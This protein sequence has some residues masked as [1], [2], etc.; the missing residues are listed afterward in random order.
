[1]ASVHCDFDVRGIGQR[2]VALKNCRQVQEIVILARNL[3]V[4]LV[5]EQRRKH[6]TKNDL[7]DAATYSC[8]FLTNSDGDSLQ[9]LPCSAINFKAIALS[10]QLNAELRK[11]FL[12]TLSVIYKHVEVIVKNI[13]QPPIDI[14][15]FHGMMVGSIGELRHIP[16]LTRCKEAFDEI[17]NSIGTFRGN[18][19][20]YWKDFVS[21]G[22]VGIIAEHFIM[23]TATK[24]T[25][26]NPV[27]ARQFRMITS[28][29]RQR[30][31]SRGG[32]SKDMKRMLEMAYG[33][34]DQLD[35]T[36]KEGASA[37]KAKA[38]SEERFVDSVAPAPEGVL[39]PVIAPPAVAPT[40]V[41]PTTAQN[42]ATKP[43]KAK[44]AAAASKP[45]P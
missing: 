27:V 15:A 11:Y 20:N 26:T 10:D 6:A 17:E 33:R 8:D 31:Q 19:S 23:D 14:D 29:Y 5:E 18:F 30:I 3:R 35:E 21:S 32:G 42:P 43:R 28:H 36:I 7:E 16:E 22:N 13:Q 12:T 45:A 38:K 1:M 34:L 39:T 4:A 37:N 2:F 9:L 25:K 40:A 41:P 44:K 24:T